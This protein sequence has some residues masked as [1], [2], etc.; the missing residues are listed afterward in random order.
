MQC[1][2]ASRDEMDWI[3]ASQLLAVRAAGLRYVVSTFGATH[4]H[5]LNPGS[6]S[7]QIKILLQSFPSFLGSVQTWREYNTL[8]N[9]LIAINIDLVL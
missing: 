6:K 8:F 4:T 2:A 5:A 7:L 3:E 1:V 9:I